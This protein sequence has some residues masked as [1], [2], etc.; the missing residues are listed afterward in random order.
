MAFVAG[1]PFPRLFNIFLPEIAIF[2]EKDY[3]QLL[4]IRRL[5]RDLHFGV[6]VLGH[7]TVREPSGLALSSRNR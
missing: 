5:A 7:P 1:N 4:L 3:Q 2:G 6:E